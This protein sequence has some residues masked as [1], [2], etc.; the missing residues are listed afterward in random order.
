MPTAETQPAGTFTLTSYDIVLF[1][2]GYAVTD[3]TQL[4]LTMTPPIE[5]FFPFDLSIKSTLAKSPSFRLAALGSASGV[6]GLDDGPAFIGRLGLVGQ[7]CLDDAC[8][9]SASLALSSLLLG[10]ATLVATGAGLI[11]RVSDLVALLAEVDTLVPTGRAVA[12]AHGIVAGAGLRFRGRRWAL[13]AGAF[14]S[15][16]RQGVLPLVVGTYRFLPD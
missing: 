13:D 10:P 9:S 8:A 1:Q 16:D 5:G 6:L 11:V 14:S 15:L 3:S 7:A 12:E 2:L 4:T